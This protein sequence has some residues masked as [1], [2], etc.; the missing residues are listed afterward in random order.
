M[1]GT[2]DKPE[3]YH[4]VTYELDEQEGVT[5]LVITQDGV[6]NEQAKEHSEQ[7]WKMIFD[8]LKD[9]LKKE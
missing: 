3:N 6:K 7:N 8:G 2:E 4:H 5:S 1:S 9:I